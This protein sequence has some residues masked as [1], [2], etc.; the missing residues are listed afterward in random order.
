MTPAVDT[1]PGSTL[2]RL[3]TLLE[4]GRVSNLPT[5]W[6]NA[7]A[8][9]ALSG[10]APSATMIA[11][12]TSALSAL[13]IGGMYLN[14]ACD[15]EIDARERPERPIPSGRVSQRQ[16]RIGA[17]L[18]FVLGMAL[19]ALAAGARVDWLLPALLL[20]GCIVTYDLHHKGNRH[21]ALIMGG[22]RALGYL[23]VA[24]VASGAPAWDEPWERPW[25]LLG[26]VGACFA[27]TAGLT[28]IAKLTARFPGVSIGLLIASIAVLD[29]LALALVGHLALALVA[30]ACFALTLRLQRWVSGT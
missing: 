30:L 3:R 2:D 20:I 19:F 28:Q 15:A 4:L 22:C 12:C 27:W 11:L 18:W 6:S 1:L 25:L 23:A 16:V 21:G 10:A 14:D 29:A 7:L 24:V 9:I 8:A 5:V 17:V 26:L 13:Y